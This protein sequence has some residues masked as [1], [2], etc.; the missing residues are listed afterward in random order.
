MRIK[1]FPKN[2]LGYGYF[3]NR[4]PQ[5]YFELI[6]KNDKKLT[7]YLELFE[8]S[9]Y[10][11]DDVSSTSW[12]DNFKKNL[13]NIRDSINQ[14]LG[15]YF[16][17]REIKLNII[18]EVKQINRESLESLIKAAERYNFLEEVSGIE[19]SNFINMLEKTI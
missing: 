8:I 15:R 19:F 11:N 14:I 18:N 4:I 6:E 9:R 13:Q 5:V 2:D 7:N 17:G 1:Y 10:L 16:N 3:L 12:P